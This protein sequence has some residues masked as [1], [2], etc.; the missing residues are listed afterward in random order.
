[1]EA[2]GAGIIDLLLGFLMVLLAG[3]GL[4]LPQLF[5]AVMAFI[6]F[7]LIVALVWLRLG[8]VDIALAEAM[9]GSGITGALFLAALGRMAKDAA[10]E[11]SDPAARGPGAAFIRLRVAKGANRQVIRWPSMAAAAVIAM[12]TALVL[13][14]VFPLPAPDGRI[15]ALVMRNLPDS[16][17]AN[18]VTAVL[19]NFRAYDTLLEIGVV[20][21]ALLGLKAVGSHR[22]TG[23]QSNPESVLTGFYRLSLPFLILLSAY[24]VWVGKDEPG[25]AFQAAALLAAGGILGCMTGANR[26]LHGLPGLGLRIMVSAGLAVFL[27]LGMISWFQNGAF[28]KFA[29]L[30]AGLAIL[31]IEVVATISIALSLTV[32]FLGSS[33]YPPSSLE[34]RPLPADRRGG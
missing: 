21:L 15:P 33:G 8:A 3:A 18:P 12:A 26:F 28:L 6:G 16:G 25:G 9:I 17:V 10:K 4:L 30:S 11:G 7:G 20:L 31:V 29:P 24:M 1:M 5:R 27:S 23:R 34:S 22:Q 2:A 13:L 19:L 14:K 32:L